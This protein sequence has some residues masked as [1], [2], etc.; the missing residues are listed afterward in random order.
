MAATVNAASVSAPPEFHVLSVTEALAAEKVDQRR[1]LSTA[2]AAQRREAFGPNR[3]ADP[4]Q[5]VLLAAGIGSLY[6]LK[7]WGTGILLILLT[8]FNAA[9]G[10]HQEG[11][12]AAAIG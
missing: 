12:A 9:L 4:M 11:K 8:L 2:E 10:M 3:Y 5:I 1:G 7:Q 6:P